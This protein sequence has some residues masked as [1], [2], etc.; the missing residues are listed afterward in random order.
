M[1]MV[2]IA[3]TSGS[4][5][6]ERE[7][8]YRKT[9]YVGCPDGARNDAMANSSK[10]V[11]KQIR[12]LD[13]SDGT[14]SGSVTSRNAAVSEAPEVASR[15]AERGVQ[16][17]QPRQDHE[18]RERHRDHHVAEDDGDERRLHADRLH[19]DEQPDGERDV[20]HDQRQQQQGDGHGAHPQPTRRQPERGEDAQGGCQQRRDD[21]RSRHCA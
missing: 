6:G 11:V 20:R 2:P 9:G 17:A 19:E 8:E 1:T 14:S 7:L 5:A 10:L 15:L 21:A 12:K 4:R 18:N 13:T 3:I 16:R